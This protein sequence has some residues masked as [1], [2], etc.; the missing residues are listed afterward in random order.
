MVCKFKRDIAYC[1]LMSFPPDI[2]I[3]LIMFV[4]SLNN[5][6]HQDWSKNL[7]NLTQRSIKSDSR[8]CSYRGLESLQYDYMLILD[9]G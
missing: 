5:K 9:Q 3:I 8:A 7:L 1:L 6:I 2:Q 4:I